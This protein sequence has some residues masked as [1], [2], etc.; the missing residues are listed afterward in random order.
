MSAAVGI[1]TFTQA[2]A[3][4]LLELVVWPATRILAFIAVAPLFSN[5]W[6]P[7]LWRL[8]FGLA[9][10]WSIIPDLPPTIP[11]PG[12]GGGLVV[13]LAQVVTG[14][15][16][17]FLFRFL[18][19][20]F[21]FAAGWIA[22]T[23]GL[24]FATTISSQYGEQ[25]STLSEI[26]KYGVVFLLIADG[27]IMG[28][29]HVLSESFQVIPIGVFWPHWNWL[30]L[31]DFG[32][33]LFTEGVLIAMPVVLMLL[34]VNVGMAIIARVAPQINLFAIGFPIM[35]LVGLAG[36]YVLVPYLPRMVSHLFLLLTTNV[37]PG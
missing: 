11:W 16:I 37:L 7:T 2:Q 30:R 5:G 35:I 24:G 13:L 33:V 26:F 32:Q 10:A 22:L 28:M 6:L 4:H 20:I 14:L 31:A 15:S 9:C 8:G 25:S 1:I 29:L 12:M 3:N 17:G 18:V 19:G 21:E 23:M 36:T 34:V 27:G